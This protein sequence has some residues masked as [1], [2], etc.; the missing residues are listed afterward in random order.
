M[1]TSY[2]FF[3]IFSVAKYEDKH[4]IEAQ[5]YRKNKNRLSALTIDLT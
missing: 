3:F 2:I 5:T 4:I 1:F